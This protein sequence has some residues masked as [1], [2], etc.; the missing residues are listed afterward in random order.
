MSTGEKAGAA[1][2]AGWLMGTAAVA[3]AFGAPSALAQETDAAAITVIGIRNVE[4]MQS[5]KATAPILD[6]PVS[7][8]VIPSEVFEEQGARNLTDVLNN[9]PG[10]TFNA[11]ENGFATGLSNFSLRGFDASANIF[12]DGARDS[13]AYN[14]DAFNIDRVEVVKGPAGDNG[15]GGAGG[16]VN[17][18]TRTPLEEASYGIETSYG[19][20]DYEFEN[21]WRTTLDLNQP[22]SDTAAGRLAVLYEDG[23]VAGREVA[24]RN[25]FGFAPSLALGL[26]T[27]TRLILSAQYVTQND[28]PDW[29]VPVALM[30]GMVNYDPT[31][32]SGADHQDLRDVYYGLN[33]DFDDVGS[34]AVR[35]RIERT[36]ST[37]LEF[38]SQLRWSQTDRE[39]VYTLPSGYAAATDLVTTQ[40]QAYARENESL[41]WLNNFSAEFTTGG[42]E[43]SAAFGL[44]YSRE[45]ANARAFATQANPGGATQPIDN[46]DPDRAGPFTAA[47]TERSEVRVNTLAAYLYDTIELSPRWEVSGGLRVETYDVEID[48]ETLGGVPTGADGHDISETTLAGR[49]GLVFHPSETSSLYAA[50][51]VAPQPPAAFLSNSDI[52]RGGDNAFPGFSTGLNSEGVDVQ[53]SVNYEI[54]GKWELLDRRLLATAALFRTERQ[55]VAI[56]GRT[57]LTTADPIALLGYGEHIVEGLELGLSGQ[58]TPQ[59]SIFAGALFMQSERSHGAELDLYRCRAQPSDYGLT[60]TNAGIAACDAALHGTRGDALAFTPETSANLWTTYE[61]PFGLTVGGGARFVGE[62]VCR[63]PGRRRAH[64]PQQR[65][66]HAARILGGQCGHLLRHRRERH[67]AA[68]HRQHHRRILCRLDQLVGAARDPRAAALVLAEPERA[69]V[70]AAHAC[71]HPRCPH[72][73]RGRARAAIAGGGGVGGRARHCRPPGR[74]RQAQPPAAA[75]QR[76]RARA[77][78]DDPSLARRQHAIHVGGAAAARAPADLQPLRG[79]RGVR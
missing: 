11:G 75:R 26:S 79:R 51:G 48:S 64:H 14:R 56:T 78:R 24:S 19:F 9:T 38:S 63:A 2:L 54:G 76:R 43:H 50:V 47:P 32:I 62:S 16:Y 31:L 73:R 70:K 52:S 45:Q 77:G 21:R 39:A 66:Q 28:R 74:S 69:D 8:T 13:G 72:A 68:Q 6:L 33:S 40:R 58:I 65:R 23:G 71:R 7:V 10:I 41:S 61:F 67:P 29:G 42:L 30:E 34:S 44:E 15:R 12:I 59:W 53:R 17:I 5:D 60:N 18:V 4:E 46:P 57:G 55:N 36:L 1:R 37:A 3:A 35:A 20:D 25:T 49:L 27:D 22:F